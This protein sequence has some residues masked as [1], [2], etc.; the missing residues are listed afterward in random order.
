MPF[1]GRCAARVAKTLTAAL[2]SGL[3]LSA[4]TGS[5]RL[6]ERPPA[7]SARA[8]S[9]QLWAEQHG[10]H[11][12]TGKPAGTNRGLQMAWNSRANGAAEL[13]VYLE[14]DGLAWLNPYTPSTDPTPVN[15]LGLKLAVQDPS[16]AAYLGRVCQFGWQPK[17]GPC[18]VSHWTSYRYSEEAIALG[19]REMDRLKAIT[20]AQRLKLVGY[21]G[22]GA[23]ALLLA[24]RRTDV[25]HI[26]TVAGN[27]DT[28]TWSR[29]TN[30]TPL[31]GSLNP[32]DYWAAVADIPQRHWVGADDKTMPPTVALQ[33]VARLPANRRPAVSI[34][35]GFDH[36]CCWAQEWA[37]LLQVNP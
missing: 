13:T 37:R 31:W 8:Q 22:G 34:K 25:V 16:P 11:W 32:A 27:L 12:Q 3:F 10:W 2:C 17:T 14:G 35:D 28:A 26:T 21:S 18:D 1:P 7:A 33:Y 23:M 36:Q 4:C 19:E 6:A 15:A 5:P 9:A 30:T 20:G 29:L 24:G